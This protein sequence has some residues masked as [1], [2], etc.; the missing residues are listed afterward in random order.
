MDQVERLDLMDH[1]DQTERM[2][3]QELPVLQVQVVRQVLQVLP[4]LQVQVERPV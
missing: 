2:V 4:V 3:L 1:Q